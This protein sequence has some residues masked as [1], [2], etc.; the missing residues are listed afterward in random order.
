MGAPPALLELGCC[1]GEQLA[2]DALPA[3]RTVYK[4]VVDVHDAIA[5]V[6][7]G[8]LAEYGAIICEVLNVVL[9]GG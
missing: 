4:G 3:Q 2:R 8:N 7:K 6:W 5:A 9:M 1:T